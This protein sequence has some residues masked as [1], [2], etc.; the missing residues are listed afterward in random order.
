MI[1]VGHLM[2]YSAVGGL[3]QMVLNLTKFRDRAR[4]R[5][6]V[7]A[8]HEGPML[9]EMRAAGAE[10]Y[11]GRAGC[12]EVIAQADILNL[13]WSGFD[14]ERWWL[15]LPLAS[16]KPF[17]TTLHWAAVIPKLPAITICT[18]EYTYRIQRHRDR[19]I[20]IPNGVD[21]ERFRP[22]AR[23]D[24]GRVVI[25]RVCRPE[26]CAMYFWPAMHEVLRACPEAVLW[27]V[28]NREGGARQQGRVRFW[29]VVRNVEAILAES[30]I[31][32]YTPF[33]G[34]G[35]KDLVTM[36][37]SAAGLPCVTSNVHAVWESV[38]DARN[39]YLTPYGDG[40]AFS[41]QVAELIRNPERRREMGAA[42]AQMARERFDAR[43]VSQR[44]EAV[45]HVVLSGQAQGY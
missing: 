38:E 19:C 13:H 29:G 37:A 27:I 12:A 8:P 15:A 43:R 28:G 18:S 41:R 16:G 11:L 1:K 45:Y 30:N 14:S 42:G 3:E 44:Y 25:T 20:P 33:S 17:V 2:P 36:E 9:S 7:A 22:S 6:L 26:K 10:I 32:A 34:V 4:Y 23:K 39:G 5:S 40:R 31:F 35:S 21:L 24:S